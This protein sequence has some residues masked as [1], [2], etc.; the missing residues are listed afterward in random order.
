MTDSGTA[1]PQPLGITGNICL[2]NTTKFSSLCLL[3]SAYTIVGR[4]VDYIYFTL[5]KIGAD[6]CGKAELFCC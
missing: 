2:L 4:D 1:C 3:L 5:K 6:G